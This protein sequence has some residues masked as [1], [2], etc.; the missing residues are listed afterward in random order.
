MTTSLNVIVMLPTDVLRG[1]GETAVIAAVGAEISTLHESLA[2]V[3]S[4]FVTA[5]MMPDEA[6]VSV[7][8]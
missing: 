1:S 3:V 5:S 8:K 2:L 7:S 4:A 6:A